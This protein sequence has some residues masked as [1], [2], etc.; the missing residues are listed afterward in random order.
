MR[1]KRDKL[2]LTLSVAVLLLSSIKALLII[3]N[4]N[5]SIRLVV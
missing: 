4:V 3:V 5:L 1:D 2:I